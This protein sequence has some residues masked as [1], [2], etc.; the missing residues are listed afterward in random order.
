MAAREIESQ[1]KLAQ[2]DHPVKGIISTFK[3]STDLI[4]NRSLPLHLEF[5]V[6][7]AGAGNRH[8]FGWRCGPRRIGGDFD[9]LLANQAGN[10]LA[11]VRAFDELKLFTRRIRAAGREDH[12]APINR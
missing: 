3:N 9:R 5:D 6:L 1:Y 11:T 10:R 4:L 7:I 12:E 2:R 8:G